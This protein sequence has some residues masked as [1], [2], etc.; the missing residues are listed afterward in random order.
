M[1]SYTV[2]VSTIYFTE[3]IQK[4]SFSEVRKFQYVSIVV[5]TIN[6]VKQY[7]S[8]DTNLF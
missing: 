1:L 8:V 7:H 2:K 5:I 3:I 4:L 6:I